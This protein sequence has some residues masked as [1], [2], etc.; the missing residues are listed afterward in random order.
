MPVQTTTQVG[1]SVLREPAATV[2]NFQDNSLQTLVTNLTDTMRHEQ[3]VGIAAPQIGIGLEVFVSEIRE[4]NL[5]QVP[6]EPLTKYIN[7][8]IVSVSHETEVDFEGCGSVT[9][10]LLSDEVSR[11][12]EAIVHYLPI[13]SVTHE[14]IAFG[15]LKQIIQSKITICNGTVRTDKCNPRSL[16]SWEHFLKRF[17]TQY[18]KNGRRV[19]APALF[20]PHGTTAQPTR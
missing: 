8:K 2:I 9:S 15:L 7:P 4:K 14:T 13:D 5:R 19:G 1:A 10:R 6:P 18:R 11:A 20:V 3:L 16:I 17:S 12:R